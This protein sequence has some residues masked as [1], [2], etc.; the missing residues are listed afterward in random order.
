MYEIV[1]KEIFFHQENTKNIHFHVYAI[2][3]QLKTFL[4]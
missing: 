1:T 4:T 3:T 2:K